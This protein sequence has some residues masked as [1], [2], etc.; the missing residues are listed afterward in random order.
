MTIEEIRAQ[1][2]R[3]A[4]VFQTGGV[5]PT[6]HLMESW[7]GF[8]GWSFPEEQQPSGYQP[9]A[10]FFLQDLPYVP[11]AL[12]PFQLLTVFVHDHVYDHLNEDDLRPYFDIRTYTTLEGLV[13]R[14]WQHD[15]LRAFPLMPKLITNDYPLWD[16]GGIPAQLEIEILTLEQKEALDYFDDIVE[17]LYPH[18]KIGG[19]PTFCQS[20]I[21]FGE[22][23]P[24]VLQI[25]SDAKAQLNIVD[26][27]N[28]Y[29]FYNETTQSWH[30]Y[31]DFY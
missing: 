15:Q 30:V 18:H 1:L 3:P 19:Y 5:R 4:T 2:A 28:F 16:G 26:N 7:I 8:V 21:D 24:F 25:A 20:G 12:K 23:S 11:A 9:L 27:G 17:E 31:C 6:H 22:D 10:T 29:F 13:K 14:E